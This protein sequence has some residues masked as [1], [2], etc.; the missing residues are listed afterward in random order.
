MTANVEGHTHDA[1]SCCAIEVVYD[2]TRR[3]IRMYEQS[4]KHSSLK[5]WRPRCNAKLPTVQDA[6]HYVL[7]VYFGL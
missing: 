4:I 6:F 2:T 1:F 3:V 7:Y 5:K